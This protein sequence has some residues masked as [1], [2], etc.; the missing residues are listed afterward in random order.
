MIY[1]LIFIFGLVLGSFYMVVGSRLPLKKSIAKPRSHCEICNHY[2]QWYE[3]IPVFSYLWQKGRCRK[4]HNKISVYY[5]LCEL[6]CGALFLISFIIFGFSFKF[7]TSLIIISLLI[8]VFV[9]DFKYFIILDSPILIATILYLILEFIF[10]DIK[11]TLLSICT[12][13]TMFVIMILIM[14]LG[15]LLFKRESLGGG[16]IKLSFF[17]GIVLVPKLSLIALIFASVFALLYACIFMQIKKESEI[18]YGPFLML[19]FYLVYVLSPYLLML[20]D[21]F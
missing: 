21:S 17:I 18:P 15:N 11:T 7:L 13:V 20:L 10:L 2:L 6:L 19:G 8:I 3:L 9:S 14:L 12:G 5:P 16:D 1:L 4:C